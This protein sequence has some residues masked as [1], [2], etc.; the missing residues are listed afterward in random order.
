MDR[1]EFFF[2]YRRVDVSNRM[3]V[4]HY[5]T[6]SW[7][8][9]PPINSRMR[10]QPRA[11]HRSVTTSNYMVVYGGYTNE[12]WKWREPRPPLALFVYK[13]GL[14]IHFDHIGHLQGAGMALQ[15]MF[16]ALVIY[17]NSDE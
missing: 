11:L 3:Y 12:D 14:W 7:S 5:P 17:Q 8:L 1:S 15:G 6:R 4:L 9:V 13:C 10:P 2:I 16:V